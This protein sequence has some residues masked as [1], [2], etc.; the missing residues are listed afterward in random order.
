MPE[1][2]RQDL[3]GKLWSVEEDKR[4]TGFIPS[5]EIFIFRTRKETGTDRNQVK[6][7]IKRLKETHWYN[8]LMN[9]VHSSSTRERDTALALELGSPSSSLEKS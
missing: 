7:R 3:S 2:S 4:I 1:E 6:W 8:L 5:K 9:D